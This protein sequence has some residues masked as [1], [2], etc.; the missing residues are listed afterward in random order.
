MRWKAAEENVMFRYSI[1]II[2]NENDELNQKAPFFHLTSNSFK[3]K[4]KCYFK[5]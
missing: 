5:S 3:L 4:I 1:N 2:K